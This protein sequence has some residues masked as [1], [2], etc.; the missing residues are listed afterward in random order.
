MMNFLT[1]AKT[2]DWII[3]GL[4]KFLAIM[5]VLQLVKKIPDI[6]NSI[7]GTNIKTRGGIK[8]RLGEM[9][10]IGGLAQKAWTALGNTGKNLAKLGL[11]AP[12]AGGYLAANALYHKKTG[13]WLKDNPAFQTGKGMLYGA[14]QGLKTGSWM[15][16]YQ[17]YE[18]ESAPP[19]H[20]RA[21][22][23]GTEQRINNQLST[24]GLTT[25]QGTWSN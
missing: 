12:L 23:I 4:T 19:T 11:T 6:I 3:V 17:E 1:A 5:A 10:G 14:R 24:A 13:K 20:T 7:F 8:G 21:Q 16:G 15:T 25:K 18:K 2:A 9:A 22:L